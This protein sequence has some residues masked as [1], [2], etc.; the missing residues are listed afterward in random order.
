MTF[1]QLWF[2]FNSLVYY[3]LNV[4]SFLTLI[5]PS[6]HLLILVLE[7]QFHLLYYI[8]LQVFIIVLHLSY[9]YFFAFYLSSL[10]IFFITKRDMRIGAWLPEPNILPPY[11]RNAS[12]DFLCLSRKL[13]SKLDSIAIICSS[14]VTLLSIITLI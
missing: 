7:A 13:N 8:I 10:S 9:V 14:F 2:Y 11:L 1:C 3:R 4:S 12:T 5:P 6:F